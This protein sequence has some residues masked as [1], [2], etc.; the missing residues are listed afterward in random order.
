ML[1]TNPMI[2]AGVAAVVL[3]LVAISRSLR[4]SRARGRWEAGRVVIALSLDATRRR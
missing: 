2:A 4:T 1:S 3:S